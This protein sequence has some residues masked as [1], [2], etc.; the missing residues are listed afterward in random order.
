M[1]ART[2]PGG[3]GGLGYTTPLLRLMIVRSSV[4][5]SW[6][7]RQKSSSRVMSSTG[8]RSACRAT[9]ASRGNAS[10]WSA[11][12]AA[13]TAKSDSRKPRRVVIGSASPKGA[14]DEDGVGDDVLD[15]HQRAEHRLGRPGQPRRIEQRDH[16]VLDEPAPI[17]L[18]SRSGP[19]R[20]FEGR[21]RARPAG[22]FDGRPPYRRWHRSEERRV[23]KECRSRWS[24]YH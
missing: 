3:G 13:P 20:V 4:K 23:G 9:R 12:R 8:R 22:V 11:G 16:V 7:S 17:A 6:T 21:E 18:E 2:A 5:A 14:A 10:S 15:H 24:P 19:Q 1:S